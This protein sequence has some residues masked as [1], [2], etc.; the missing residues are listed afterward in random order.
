MSL[1]PLPPEF[2]ERDESRGPPGFGMLL[3]FAVSAVFWTVVLLAAT[4][5]R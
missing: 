4:W 2:I 1:P 5:L 3:A